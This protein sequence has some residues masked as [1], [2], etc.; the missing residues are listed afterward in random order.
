MQTVQGRQTQ[1]LG[2]GYSLLKCQEEGHMARQCTK[3]KR[4]RN[5]AWFKENML[6]VEALESRAVLDK[7]QMEFLADNKD[8]VTI[9]QESQEILTLAIFQTDDLDAYNVISY[10]Q[11]L[12]ETQNKVVQDTNSS[13]Q[14]DAM[15]MSVIEE[16]SNQVGKCNEVNKGNKTV[17]ESLTVKL[18]DF[19]NQIHMLKL[20]LS[21]TVESHKTLSTTVDVLKKES[22][23][24]EDKYL[25]EIIDLEKKK[26]AL[27]NVVY[28]MG[29]STQ[30]M[31]MLTK[32]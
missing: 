22:K 24:K 15:I 9:G 14:Q 19:Q 21:A 3:P 4:P 7:E 20:Q 28:K 25:E 16:M 10:E 11:Y 18:K 2:K 8:T 6:L 12:Q 13:A 32:P 23:A 31:H 29:Q 17:N 30:T 5:S 1:R 26:K 27:D